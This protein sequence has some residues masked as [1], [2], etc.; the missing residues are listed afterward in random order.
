MKDL[1]IIGAGGFG[2]EVAWLVERINAT[3]NT[4]EIKGFLD[5]NEKIWDS[6]IDDYPVLG[7]ISYLANCEDAYVVCAVGNAKIRKKI[8]E[9]LSGLD[10]R[11]ATLIDPSVIMSRRV[12]I[13]EGTIICAGTIITVDVTI[14]NHVIINLDC[15]LGHDDIISDY[16]TMYPSVNVS[17]C[18]NIG[19]CVELGTGMQIIQGLSVVKG[20]IVGASGCVVK[21]I[22]Y[23][24]TYVG[25]PTKK[26]K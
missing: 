3:N 9:K 24:G 2:R 6:I 15:T 5:D 1:Y 7:G 18:C 12:K 23:A 16:V 22:D 4:W 25:M 19:E 10:I 8:I 21:N 14:G 26:I 17:G 13:G 11:F 20:T